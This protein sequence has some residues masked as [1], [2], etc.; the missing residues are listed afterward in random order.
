MHEIQEQAN[1]RERAVLVGLKLARDEEEIWAMAFE[2][3]QGLVETAGAEVVTHVTQNRQLP[4]S[5]TYVGRGKLEELKAIIEELDIDLVV[6]DSELSPKHV[7]NLENALRP[8]R[9]LDRT[10][11]I[12]DIFAMRA[13]TREGKLQVELAQLNYLLPRLAGSGL[14][15]GL[16]RLGGGIGTR[17]PGETKLETDRRHIRGRLLELTRHLEEVRKHRHLH[18]RSRKKHEVPVI[19]FVGY[20]NAGKSTLMR[21][22]VERYGTGSKE[23]SEGRDRLFDTLDTTTRQ[24]RLPDGKTSIFSDTVGFIQQLP[25]A[26]VR[27]FR[28]TLEE[29]A[30]ADLIVHVVDASHPNFDVQMDTVYHVLQELQVLDRPILTVFNKIDRV[31]GTWFGNDPNSTATIRVSALN[32]DGVADMMEK[33]DDLVGVRSLII[34]AV[35]PYQESAL[36]AR[37]HREARVFEEEHRESG[38]YLRAEVPQ[39]LADELRPY[40]EEE[41]REQKPPKPAQKIVFDVTDSTLQ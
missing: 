1:R 13:N 33:V 37:L 40:L 2:E 6:F 23:V 27:A 38:T 25:H 30:E 32:G 17:G 14:G 20:T 19:A 3:L 7:R 29:T 26:L 10:Q 41:A 35:V 28:S 11:I 8:C 34:K 12:L 5:S 4:D 18:R 9:V 16:S 22:I 39:R 15:A 21:A 31:P 24:V 36:V